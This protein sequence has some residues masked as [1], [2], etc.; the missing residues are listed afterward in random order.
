MAAVSLFVNNETAML[1]NR[2]YL[3][4]AL[5]IW[6]V[7]SNSHLLPVSVLNHP[8]ESTPQIIFGPPE[9]IF[10][11]NTFIDILIKTYLNSYILNGFY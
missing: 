4:Q 11:D 7:G 8:V 2:I 9:G 3:I 6:E 5:I 10:S 1:S